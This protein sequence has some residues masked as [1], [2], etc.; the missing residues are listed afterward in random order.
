MTNRGMLIVVSGPSGVG[1]DTI[2][3]AFLSDRDDCV[4]SISATTRAPRPG[5]VNGREY[6]FIDEKEFFDRVANGKML[7]YALYND[8]Y[9]GTPVKEMD[10]LLNQGKHVI[11][12]IEIQGAQQVRA[13]RPN[14]LSVF[15]RPPCMKTLRERLAGRGT[16][17]EEEIS[18]RIETAKEEMK[19][20]QNYDYIITND[21]INKTVERFRCIVKAAECSPKFMPDLLK[22]VYCQDA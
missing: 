1:K 15:L 7:E 17:T 18:G 8:N 16:E 4:A 20:S 5:E 11:L 2:V 10:E 19:I 12:V 9:Y 6:H 13:L 14:A 21:D 22:G 3:N